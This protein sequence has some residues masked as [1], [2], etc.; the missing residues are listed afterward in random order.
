VQQCPGLLPTQLAETSPSDSTCP[1]IAEWIIAAMED[2]ADWI[3]RADAT[4]FASDAGW[5]ALQKLHEAVDA[6]EPEAELHR[7]AIPPSL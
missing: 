6:V 7:P 2:L 3:D 4:L 5:A 1:A